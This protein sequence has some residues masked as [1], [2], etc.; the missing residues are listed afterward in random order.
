ME[1]KIE[2]VDREMAE[3]RCRSDRIER[4]VGLQNFLSFVRSLGKG[5]TLDP[6]DF[7]VVRAF[8]TP[9]TRQSNGRLKSVDDSD[10]WATIV[11]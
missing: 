11:R 10:C 3:D 5:E 8:S 1:I 4:N 7:Q 2:R 6:I 9:C